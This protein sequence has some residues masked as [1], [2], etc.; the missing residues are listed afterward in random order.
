MNTHFTTKRDR[1]RCI[2]RLYTDIYNLSTN[3][4]ECFE[5]NFDK[6]QD[7]R[8]FARSMKIDAFIRFLAFLKKPRVKSFSQKCFF[9]IPCIP[10]GATSTINPSISLIPFQ[11]TQSA[12]DSSKLDNITN[13]YPCRLI[14]VFVEVQLPDSMFPLNQTVSDIKCGFFSPAWL[15]N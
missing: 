1:K 2:T 9:L 6:L 8:V 12:G 4:K 11:C 13:T 10:A 7:L 3:C 5:R 14:I 15:L